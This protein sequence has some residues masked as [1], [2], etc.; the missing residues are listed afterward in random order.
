MSELRTDEE[1]VELLKK[2]WAENGKGLVA[3][4][5]LA[6][7][8]VGGWNWWQS[9]EQAKGEAASVLY[10]QLVDLINQTQLSDEQS[11]TAQ[12]LAGQLQSDFPETLY[13]NYGALFEAKLQMNAGELDRALSTLKAVQTA[14]VNESVS[15]VAALRQA[16]IL[17]QQGNTQQALDLA[18]TIKAKVYGGDLE[19]LKG[20]LLV[21]LDKKQQAKDAYLKAKAIF[22]TAGVSRPAL[23]MKIADLGGA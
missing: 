5:V 19:E 21:E 16:Q 7:A 12:H 20:D 10:Q 8:A 17:W 23:D 9:Q 4:V 6:I 18:N 15:E 13:A 3:A 1:Q 2:W 14:A 22:A 11:A